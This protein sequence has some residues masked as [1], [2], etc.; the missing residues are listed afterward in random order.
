MRGR[1]L[2]ALVSYTGSVTRITIEL[3]DDLAERVNSA[4][5]ERGVAAEELARETL[6]HQFP[7][8][9]RVSFIGIGASGGGEAVAERHR[10]IRKAHFA[11]KTASDI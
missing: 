5:A 1:A 4:A 8:E 10:E 9:R 11:D 2:E 6:A 3:P 7:A